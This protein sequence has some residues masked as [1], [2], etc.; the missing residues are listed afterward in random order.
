M[1]LVVLVAFLVYVVVRYSPI[2]GRIFEEK[3]LFLPLALAAAGRA[4]SESV[5]APD[6]L[7]LAGTYFRAATAERVGVLVFCHEYL[8][9]RWS[10]RPYADHLRDLGF[11]V[12]TFDFRNHGDE[13]SPTRTTSRCSG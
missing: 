1:P 7:E 13:R 8:S 5:S 2:I 9:D 3:P 6:G 10:F 11:D 4:A 12:F